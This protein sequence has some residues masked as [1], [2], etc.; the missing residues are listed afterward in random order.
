MKNS[1]SVVDSYCTR[2]FFRFR[3]N[4]PIILYKLIEKPETFELLQTDNFYCI[5][6][7]EKKSNK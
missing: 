3:L 6:S 2:F 7:M 1:F 4:Y 5:K